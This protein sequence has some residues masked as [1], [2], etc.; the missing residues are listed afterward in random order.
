LA[1]GY[2]YGQPEYVEI[3]IEKN[4]LFDAFKTLLKD[5]YVNIRAN[6]GYSSL[7]FLNRCAI[8]LKEEII[9]AEGFEPENIYVGYC[10]DWDPSG[11]NMEY[12]MKRRLKML[13]VGNINF[14]R[15]AVTLEQIDKYHLP[16][17]PNEKVPNKK[18]PNP[19]TEAEFI[20]RYGNKATH[21]NAFLT[22]TRFEI[23]KNEILLPFVD[24]HWDQQI[25]DEMV[26]EY[27]IKTPE[28][29]SLTD[30]ELEEA[31]S[32]MYQ[33]ITEAF[34]PGWENEQ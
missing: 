29:P 28:P 7:D 5:R 14:I 11:E 26:E 20:R 4:D 1:T 21:L 34:R 30:E 22:E 32:R 31:R 15:I 18:M 2:W 10:G 25:Y 17:L 33:K 23:F 19:G 24:S 8:E 9:E 12:Y 16:L 3:W 6:K 13:G 27:E